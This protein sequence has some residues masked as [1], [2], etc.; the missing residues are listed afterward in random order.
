MIKYCLESF[1][2]VDLNQDFY[3]LNLKFKIEFLKLKFKLKF[4]KFSN[5]LN[6][7]FGMELYQKVDY[8]IEL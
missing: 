5:E 4:T 7:L 2:K 3:N 8:M 1:Q 6:F